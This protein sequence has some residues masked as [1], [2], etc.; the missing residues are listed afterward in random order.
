MSSLLLPSD[1]CRNSNVRLMYCIFREIWTGF[2]D[3]QADRR[4]DKQ[5][6]RQT[7]WTQYVA[8]LSGAQWWKSRLGLCRY[9]FMGY[10]WFSLPKADVEVIRF[11]MKLFRSK[12]A[13]IDAIN[14][15]MQIRFSF[16]VTRRYC[17]EM[18]E[19]IDLAFGTKAT[20][21]VSYIGL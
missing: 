2:L 17:I 3:M 19:R 11:P 4:T 15:C 1:W 6:N 16:S 21:G 5:S 9:Y 8:H 14:E 13:N 7:R 20:H 18:V 12:S 10:K